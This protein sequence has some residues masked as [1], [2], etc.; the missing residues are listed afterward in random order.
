MSTTRPP[1]AL[2]LLNA[3]RV[4]PRYAVITFAVQE[5]DLN[6]ALLDTFQIR[7]CACTDCRAGSSLIVAQGVALADFAWHPL[8]S[9]HTPSAF[10]GDQ[11]ALNLAFTSNVLQ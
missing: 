7:A 8:A 4:S 2:H 9:T 5:V 6:G 10:D 11:A 3:Q 1:L